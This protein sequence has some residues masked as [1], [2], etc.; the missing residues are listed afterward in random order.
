[1]SRGGVRR[2]GDGGGRKWGRGVRRGWG[3]EERDKTDVRGG[4]GERRGEKIDKLVLCSPN[5]FPYSTF[6]CKIESGLRPH[7]T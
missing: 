1:M 3:G 5:S 4:A 2:G 7:R 6:A